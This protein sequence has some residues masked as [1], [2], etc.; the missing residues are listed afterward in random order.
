MNKK[1][2][3]SEAFQ[4]VKYITSEVQVH[5]HNCKECEEKSE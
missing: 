5:K 4:L 3:Q 2:H 1:E